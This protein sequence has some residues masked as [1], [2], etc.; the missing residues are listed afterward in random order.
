MRKLAKIREISELTAIAVRSRGDD[1]AKQ[2]QLFEKLL[3]MGGLYVKF[4]QIL[5]LKLNSDRQNMA[6]E[7]SFLLKKTY[8]STPFE[9]IDI[10]A[11][12]KSE[13]GENYRLIESIDTEP[14]AAGSFGQVY[15]AKLT[16]GKTVAIKALRPSVVKNIHF[17]MKLLGTIAKLTSAG[18]SGAYDIASIFKKFKHATLKELNYPQEAYY[19][20]AVYQKHKSHHSVIVPK[21]HMKLCS[22]HLITQEYIGG[23]SLVDVMAQKELGV[24]PVE[25][26]KET[27]GSSLTY[28]MTAIGQLMLESM[29]LEGSAHGDPHPGNIKLLPNNKVALL[30]FGICAEAPS[31]RQA[32][33]TLIKQYQK[34][35]TGNFDLQGYTWAI[36]DLF[37]RDL[38]SAVRSLDMYNHGKISQQ[39]FDA[40]ADAAGSFYKSSEKDIDQLLRGDKFAKIFN[41]VINKNNRF[42]FNIEIEQPEFMRATLMYIALVASLGIKHE[43]LSVVYTNVV[44]ELSETEFVTNQSRTNPDEAVAIIAEW[45]EN[46]ASKDIYLYQMLSSKISTRALN[47]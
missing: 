45:L 12:L 35:F 5:L 36:I 14:C 26:T 40:I 37:V 28:Q 18:Y 46:V 20:D 43:V 3:S 15:K 38:T 16:S 6:T 22:E 25:Y 17:D 29:L 8:D 1:P 32:F 34:I 4:V 31:D 30:D 33:F 19:A 2:Y 42:G 10:I 11:L 41:N 27:I 13:L 24:D 47:V 9:P 23:I 44:N 39:F 21:T 7:Y